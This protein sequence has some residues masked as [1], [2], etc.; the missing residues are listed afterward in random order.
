MVSETFSSSE[1]AHTGAKEGMSLFLMASPLPG[2]RQLQLLL[3]KVAL[4][5]GVEIHWGITFTGLQP[6]PG[7][8]KNFCAP[9]SP[10]PPKRGPGGSQLTVF[11]DSEAWAPPAADSIQMRIAR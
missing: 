6:P 3:L 5:L 2:I 4:L 1:Q 10:Y 11:P 9:G 7:K 8:G